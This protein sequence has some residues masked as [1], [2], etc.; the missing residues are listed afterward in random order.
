MQASL[1]VRPIIAAALLIFPVLYVGSYLALVD[2]STPALPVM[3]FT[4]N[5][6]S[7]DHYPRVG[8]WANR[9]YWPLERVDRNLRPETWAE[10]TSFQCGHEFAMPV[11]W[12]QA[13]EDAA[14]IQRPE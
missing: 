12:K 2:P 4:S 6:F 13:V 14:R 7:R 8:R 11:D 9:L 5:G 10:W 3:T 1:A